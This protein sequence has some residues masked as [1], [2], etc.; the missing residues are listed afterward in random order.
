MGPAIRNS[1]RLML[2]N[3]VQSIE[4]VVDQQLSW[5]SVKWRLESWRTGRRYAEVVF[6]HTL[7]F[8]VEHVF[9]VHR[10][11]GIQ[12]LHVSSPNVIAWRDV[13]STSNGSLSPLRVEI[14]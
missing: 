10:A 2:Q 5:R 3:F 14:E 8:Q 9:L 13:D 12:L 4:T 11:D 7:L 1:V 6:R